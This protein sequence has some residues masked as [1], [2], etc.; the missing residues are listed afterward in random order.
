M[1]PK[2]KITQTGWL[3]PDGEFIPCPSYAHISTARDI[4]EK[5]GTTTK[6]KWH[7]R[8][9]SPDG[10]LYGNGWISIEIRTMWEH[11]IEFCRNYYAPVTDIQAK[12][13]REYAERDDVKPFLTE[14][15]LK[16]LQSLDDYIDGGK[17][18]GI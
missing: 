4:V 3:S 5:I 18:D 10:I 7:L 9:N 12:M 15:C 13:L 8:N 16:V 6:Y 14:Y 17:Q 11:G 2:R 1:T